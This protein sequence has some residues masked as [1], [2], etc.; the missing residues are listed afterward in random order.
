M[1]SLNEYALLIKLIKCNS[2]LPNFL[3]FDT[4][5]GIYCHNILYYQLLYFFYTQGGTLL[6][7]YTENCAE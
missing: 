2:L 4:E 3:L 1:L 6:Q 7:E 5:R